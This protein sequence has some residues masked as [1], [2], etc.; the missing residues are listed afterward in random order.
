MTGKVDAISALGL[1]DSVPTSPR[2]GEAVE[3]GSTGNR[4]IYQWN[5]EEAY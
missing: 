4:D 5:P 1:R 2:V 3:V